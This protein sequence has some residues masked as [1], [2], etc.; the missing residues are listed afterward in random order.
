MTDTGLLYL[1]TETTRL[2]R[3]YLPEGRRVWE[4]GGERADPD[5]N[6]YP[7]H[8]FIRIADLQ[9][10]SL[11][12]PPR[13]GPMREEWYEALPE[14]VRISLRIGGFHERHP[15]RIG[16]DQSQ[17]YGEM[18]AAELLMEGPWLH[19]WEDQRPVV[20]GAVTNFDD[21]GL[22]DLLYRTGYV[23]PDG[24]PWN[25]HLI[26]V[27]T[28]VA[29]RLGIRPPWDSG[30]LSRAAGVDPELYRRHTAV[31]DARWARALYDFV[32]GGGAS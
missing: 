4:F 13:T 25:Y 15:E 11:L 5:G 32:F 21:L 19:R 27:E 2:R 3:P 9:L 18:D 29:G 26:D 22:F 14:D 23:G 10:P 6:E 30:A 1:D 8:M 17:V 16:G 20:I 7:L 12:S 31:D 24:E 28:A